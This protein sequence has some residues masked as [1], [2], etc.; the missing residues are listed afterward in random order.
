MTTFAAARSATIDDVVV[1]VAHVDLDERAAVRLELTQ[2]AVDD[3]NYVD[4]GARDAV[5]LAYA[6]LRVAEDLVA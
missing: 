5:W 3:K 2:L 1:S 4:L 6:I